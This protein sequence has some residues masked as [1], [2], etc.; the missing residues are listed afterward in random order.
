M[1]EASGQTLTALARGFNELPAQRKLGLMVALAAV[2]A[3]IVGSMMWAQAP[4][5]RVLYG[6]LA[7]RDGGAVIESLQKQNIPFKTGDGGVILV[8]SNLV[9]EA[10]LKLASQ[11]LPKGGAAGFELMDNQRFGITQFQENI[12]FQRAL[13]GEITRTIETISSVQGA[14]V[15]LAIPKPTVF[16]REEQK[17]S[18]SVLV[19]LYPGRGLD[20]AQVAGIV[21]L[22]ASSVPE[23]P[24]GNVTVIDQNGNML[25]SG[26]SQGEALGLDASQL[27]Y[28]KQVE[29]DYARRIEGIISPIVG[30]SNIHAQV[31]ADL[32]F[33][34]TEQTAET[35]KPNPTP[36]QSSIRSQQTSETFGESGQGAGGVPGALSNQPPGAATAPINAPGAR[37]GAT[38]QATA[39][40]G[41]AV[42][43]ESTTNFELDKTISHT[44]RPMG[45]IKRLSVAVVVNNKSTR[46]KKGKV[47]Y[48]AL[49]KEELTQVYNLA[50]EAMGFSQARGDTLN[51]VNAPFNLVEGEEIPPLPVW[52][53]PAMQSL[54]KDIVKY[55][56]IAGLLMYLVLGVIKPMMRELVSI[57]SARMAKTATGMDAVM[58]PGESA[59]AAGDSGEVV[60]LGG[61]KPH[62]YEEDLKLVKSMAKQEPKIIANVVKDWVNKE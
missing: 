51:V 27:E 50:K 57:G 26:G 59:M 32:D 5:Y 58:E 21:H 12:N 1:A 9:Y 28:L 42:H 60:T 40:S 48:Q 29:Q 16:V 31:T 11:G 24:P 7:D 38:A 47:T 13:E 61:R 41:G 6:N 45:S 62:S 2:I 23:M 53:D 10:R 54:A 36:D 52:K 37:A 3:L 19:S 8:P 22:V 15:H 39:A 46:D 25:T 30:A 43:K 55:L 14:R 49:T 4:D 17:P 44:K 56:V 34:F 18:A 20:K 35:Y 33:S